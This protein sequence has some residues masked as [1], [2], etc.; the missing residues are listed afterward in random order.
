MPIRRATESDLDGIWAIFHEVVEAGDTFPHPPGTT[1]EEAR[2]YWFAA[3]KTTYVACDKEDGSEI[4]GAYYLR[5]NQVGLGSHVANAG[6]IV[7]KDQRGRGV[8]RALG[9]HSLA[10]AAAAGYRAMQFNL[11]V[12]TNT[13]SV[14]LWK[15]LGFQIIGTLPGGFRHR[16]QGYVDAYVMYR[17][18]KAGK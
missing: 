2:E 8:G 5:P 15:K 17:E 18:L 11:V 9:E 3:D 10:E 4:V 16:E 12:R 14:E 6:Y 13:A 7:R 1:R